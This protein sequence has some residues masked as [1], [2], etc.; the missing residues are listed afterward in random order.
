LIA[1]AEQGLTL[2]GK[3]FNAVRGPAGLDLD[4]LD[5]IRE[6]VGEVVILEVKSAKKAS[7][8]P[9]FTGHFFSVS[10]AELLTAQSLG[11]RYRFVFV[12][13]LTRVT[14]ECSLMEVYGRARGIYPSWGIQF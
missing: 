8:R 9:D 1:F 14:K 13:T 10:P 6:H 4:S 2:H 11:S 7:V 5:S 3:A 12:N